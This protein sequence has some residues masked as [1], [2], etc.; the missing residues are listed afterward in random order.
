MKELKIE[1]FAGLFDEENAIYPGS[2]R[3]ML[4]FRIENGRL[5]KREGYEFLASSPYANGKIT[6]LCYGKLLRFDKP[7]LFYAV[8]GELMRLDLDTGETARCFYIN[9]DAENVY[10]FIH[11]GN[12]YVLDGFCYCKYDGLYRRTV[13]GYVPKYLV[14]ASPSGEGTRLESVNILNSHICCEYVGDGTSKDYFLPNDMN[15]DST[16]C[17]ASI[18]GVPVYGVT[19]DADERK[20]TF[21]SAPARY[22][23]VDIEVSHTGNIR[24]LVDNMCYGSFFSGDNDMCLFAWGDKNF[25]CRRI[26]SAVG[27]PE[28]FPKNSMGNIGTDEFPITDIVRHFDRQIIFTAKGIY[29]SCVSVS[30]DG[31]VTFPVFSVN[32]EKGNKAPG[33]VQIVDNDPVF[34]GETP[35]ILRSTNVRD[36]RKADIFCK[37]IAGILKN[38]DLS[39]AVCC[40]YSAKSEYWIS[41]PSGVYIYNYKSGAYY[42][43]SPINATRFLEVNGVLYFGAEDGGIYRF[44]DG[45]SCDITESGTKAIRAYAETAW[46]SPEGILCGIS[47]PR[48]GGSFTPAGRTDFKL[49]FETEKGSFETRIKRNDFS[50]DSVRFDDFVFSLA[51]IQVPFT[52]RLG[53][54]NFHRSR[55]KIDICEGIAKAEIKSLSL[56][57]NPCGRATIR[58]GE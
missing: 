41:L 3:N 6:G 15:Y 25:P 2:L 4:N 31:K 5:K 30:D 19:F 35:M 36:E 54:K 49:C 38:E 52:L 46:F 40:D 57:Y 14:A 32:S 37:E 8:S 21:P 44:R 51:D 56:P 58:E 18:N 55:I 7:Y 47:A 43:F 34:I 27:N 9:E 45:L 33:M 24:Y 28:Y 20:V 17:I 48:I 53:E 10:M 42:R 29:Y 12:I 23:R 39:K 11:N 16:Y 22:A 1:G 13:E 26:Y 50:F